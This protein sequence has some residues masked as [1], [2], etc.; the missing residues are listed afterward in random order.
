[1][2]GHCGWRG[3]RPRPFRARCPGS[4]GPR[5][6]PGRRLRRPHSRQARRR[7]PLP[8]AARA[9]AAA[10]RVE[11]HTAV[12]LLRGQPHG[13][14]FEHVDCTRVRFRTLTEDEI[15][16]YVEIDRPFDCAGGFRSEGLGSRAVRVDRNAATRRRSS[17]CRSS[18]SP[19]ALRAAGLDPLAPLSPERAATPAAARAPPPGRPA[20]APR[21]GMRRP[22]S[23]QPNAIDAACRN[24]RRNPSAR[25][26]ALHSRSPYFSSP[27]TGCPANAACTRIWCVRPVWIATSIRV[28]SVAEV[29]PRHEN[30]DRDLARAMH[31]H[32]TFA[33][34][35]RIRQH[36]CVDGLAAQPPAAGDERRVMLLDRPLAQQRVNRTQR[37]CACARPA[38]IRSC[39]D[40][41]GARAR[42][43]SSGRSARSA[44]IAPNARPEPPWTASPAGLFST[45]RRASS[46][47]IAS[48]T[49]A[50]SASGTRRDAGRRAGSSRTGGRRTSSSA[51]SR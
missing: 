16:R 51:A 14:P 44:S 2:S 15:A 5:L 39:P 1:M 42:A 28:A 20:M 46:C 49:V 35:A 40:R 36:R 26:R 30:R 6:G 8:R 45:S 23:G 33:A 7:R 27:A 34:L 48:R 21:C 41:A 17:A 12:V 31:A 29:F 22:S 47:T 19:G 18:G 3:P 25:S 38:G 9:R 10:R 24:I 37:S 50:S 43:D 32:D 11:F 13:V 4:L